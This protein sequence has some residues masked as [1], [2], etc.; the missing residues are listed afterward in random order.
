MSAQSPGKAQNWGGRVASAVVVFG[1]LMSAVM[2]LSHNPEMVPQFVEK[3]GYK[4]SALTPI[5]VVE[6][7]PVARPELAPSG[8]PPHR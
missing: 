5:G 2:K 8:D 3:F 4:E 6:V 1:L 7:A